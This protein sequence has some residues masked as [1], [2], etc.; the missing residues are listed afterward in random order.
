MKTE[1]E[2]FKYLEKIST[3]QL[4]ENDKA[5]VKENSHCKIFGKLSI[6]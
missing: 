6:V 5:F 2:C 4:S 3:P 1:Q